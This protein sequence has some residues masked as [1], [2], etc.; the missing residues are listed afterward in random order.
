[1]GT[2]AQACILHTHTALDQAKGTLSGTLDS[3]TTGAQNSFARL[4]KGADG[5]ATRQQVDKIVSFRMGEALHNIT[6]NFGQLDVS[7][8]V[9]SF[10]NSLVCANVYTS[11]HTHSYTHCL[12]TRLYT[13]P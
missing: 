11:C 4:M 2:H 5:V 10:S 9:P 6:S 7:Q 1:M 3:S 8:Q 12:N 13:C